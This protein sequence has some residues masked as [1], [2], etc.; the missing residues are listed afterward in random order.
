MWG[1]RGVWIL[2]P[3]SL[4]ASLTP[5]ARVDSACPPAS[6]AHC[7]TTTRNLYWLWPLQ[8]KQFGGWT[9]S[10]TSGNWRFLTGKTSS[11]FSGTT[12]LYTSRSY[13]MPQC[14]TG[15][16]TSHCWKGPSIGSSNRCSSCQASLDLQQSMLYGVLSARKSTVTPYPE[17]CR[18]QF[19]WQRFDRQVSKPKGLNMSFKEIH[20]SGIEAMW[21]IPLW[22]AGGQ[23][24]SMNQHNMIM[25]TISG[26]L[27]N[28]RK[29][30]SKQTSCQRRSSDLAASGTPRTRIWSSLA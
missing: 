23:L 4:V 18:C 14:E 11:L 6:M 3:S 17:A 5:D 9:L 10:T 24:P 25:W 12:R 15:S 28:F 20:A 2:F 19:Y 27:P 26:L 13:A 21:Q 7:S 8:T 29:R 16:P 30:P 22:F 1:L